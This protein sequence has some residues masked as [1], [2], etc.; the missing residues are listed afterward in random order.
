M[1]HGILVTVTEQTVQGFCFVITAFIPHR[2]RVWEEMGHVH[3]IHNCILSTT[4]RSM[5]GIEQVLRKYLLNGEK[6]FFQVG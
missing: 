5:P 3:V 1:A 4:L 6:E 2:L